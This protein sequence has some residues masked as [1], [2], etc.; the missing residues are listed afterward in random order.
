MR[1]I[2]C[3]FFPRDEGGGKERPDPSDKKEFAV[4]E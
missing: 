3:D 4:A 1:E 2:R